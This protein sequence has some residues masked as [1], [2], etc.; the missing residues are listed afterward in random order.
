[1]LVRCG[2]EENEVTRPGNEEGTH[3]T[4]Y[5][6][7]FIRELPRL[8]PERIEEME[9]MNPRSP[10]EIRQELEPEKV[11]HGDSNATRP[12]RSPHTHKN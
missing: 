9:K 5:L 2:I 4:W 1:M 6:V 8:T 10:E 12:S 7:H 11:L 3:G